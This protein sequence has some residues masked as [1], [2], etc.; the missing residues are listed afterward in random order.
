MI[1]LS[2]ATRKLLDLPASE[3]A[4]KCARDIWVNYPAAGVATNMVKHLASLPR[5]ASNPG[6]ALIGSPGVGKSYL[7]QRWESESVK[8]GAGWPGRVIYIDMS[9]ETSS[10]DVEK[11]FLQVIGVL[12]RGQPF[13]S[14]HQD[15]LAAI[16]A[17]KALNVR[18]VVFDEIRDLQEILTKARVKKC[19]AA[20]KGF[21][22]RNWQLNVVVVGISG[23]AEML[24]GDDQLSTRY[25]LRKMNLPDW[26]YGVRPD[27]SADI[28]AEVFQAMILGVMCYM[29][30]K[31]QSDVESYEFLSN[32]QM[33]AASKL[34]TTLGRNVCPLRSVMDLVRESCMQAIW[35][36][37]ERI[38]AQSL[39]RTKERML[40]NFDTDQ[41]I[42]QY[43]RRNP[44]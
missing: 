19:L 43:S 38:D 44:A 21:A 11:R 1:Q 39:K 26:S 2:A 40:G 31:G 20:L 10:L 23:L 3:R 13:N 42:E 6:L 25:A 27:G 34:S 33:L 12:Y 28:I 30:L 41:Y 8:P 22:G 35:S 32:L 7:A 36:G 37:E 4:L 29:P 9:E 14:S 16:R 15:Y 5:C 24:D 18:V 17:V